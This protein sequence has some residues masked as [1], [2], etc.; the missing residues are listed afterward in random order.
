MTEDDDSALKKLSALSNL[1][2]RD[3]GRSF[4]EV[5]TSQW[6]LVVIDEPPERS[7]G[8]RRNR[9]AFTLGRW[10]SRNAAIFRTFP[11]LS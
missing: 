7:L 11:L 2:D 6:L 9:R 3:E 8:T 5:R 10:W 1:S 4:K